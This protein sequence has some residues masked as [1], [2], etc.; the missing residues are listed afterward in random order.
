MVASVNDAAKRNPCTPSCANDRLA[1]DGT[2]QRVMSPLEYTTWLAA[3]VR[4]QVRPDPRV[5]AT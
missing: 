1:R 5:F 2:T 4:R 3:L